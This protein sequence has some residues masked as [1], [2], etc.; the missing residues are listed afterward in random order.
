MLLTVHWL[1][2]SD[3]APPAAGCRENKGMQTK[4]ELKCVIRLGLGVCT[5]S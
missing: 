2:G 4:R 3:G 1:T 5:V